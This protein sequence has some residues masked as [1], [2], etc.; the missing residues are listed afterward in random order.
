MKPTAVTDQDFKGGFSAYIGKKYGYPKDGSVDCTTFAS[1]AEAFSAKQQ[2][3]KPGGRITVIETTW[4]YGEQASPP[5]PA[6]PAGNPV[7]AAAPSPA[8]GAQQAAPPSGATRPLTASERQFAQNEM[9]GSKQYCESD[10]ALAAVFDCDRFAKAVY[11]YRVAHPE[12]LTPFGHCATGGGCGVTEPLGN[13]VAVGKLDCTD[14]LDDEKVMKWAA[15]ETDSY[16][17]IM[18]ANKQITDAKLKQMEVCVGQQFL[19]RFPAKPYPISIKA[20]ENEALEAC[21]K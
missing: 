8:A 19:A 21:G 2:W 15:R 3:I 6:V 5:G 13:L 14:C 11:N 18:I 1:Q 17:T 16:M 4:S 20:V 10:P 12:G 9:P 7:A